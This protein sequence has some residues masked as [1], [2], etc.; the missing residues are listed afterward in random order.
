VRCQRELEGLARMRL[1]KTAEPDADAQDGRSSGLL[2][3]LM[4]VYGEVDDEA[5]LPA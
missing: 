2:E 3:R 1:R 4:R 5:G